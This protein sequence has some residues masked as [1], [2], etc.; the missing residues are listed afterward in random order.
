MTV[1]QE[2]ME[3]QRGLIKK[4]GTR[5]G[6]KGNGGF[7][8]PPLLT[9]PLIPLISIPSKDRHAITTNDAGQTLLHIDRHL[10]HELSFHAFNMLHGKGYK[11][12]RPDQT[13]A[14]PDHY[15]PTTGLAPADFTDQEREIMNSHAAEGARMILT[16]DQQLDL[17][18][19]VAYEHHIMIDG[20]GYPSLRYPRDCHFASKL[21]HVCDVYDA[22]R[23]NRPYRSP[24]PAE[25]VMA[26][27]DEKS[28]TEFDGA[29]AHAFTAMMDQWEPRLST[30]HGDE[31]PPPTQN[32]PIPTGQVAGLPE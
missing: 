4:G 9:I 6:L 1:N 25:K 24:W 20:G 16:S 10:C 14:V 8:R 31:T 19:A 26:Y 11:V 2:G 7:C 5:V 21:V 23:T 32:S 3:P 30:L 15:T 22:L 28:G 29:M 12:R 18:A 17:A 27:I 13:F